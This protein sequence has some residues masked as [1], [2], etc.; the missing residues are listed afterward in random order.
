MELSD[1]EI[2]R[3]NP[4][5]ASSARLLSH[6]T[7][8]REQNRIFC[9]SLPARLFR[10]LQTYARSLVSACGLKF[11]GF[12][13]A[14]Q[15]LLSGLVQTMISS[16]L[17][18]FFK[19]KFHL[20]PSIVQNF[21]ALIYV[22]WAAKPLIG[23]FSDFFPILGYHKRYY[24][25]LA[26]FLG[27]LG[28]TI[29]ILGQNLAVGLVVSGFVLLSI[30]TSCSD[31]LTEGTYSEIAR[32][33]PYSASHVV[34][35]AFSLQNLGSIAAVT[36]VG[37]LSDSHNYFPI[38]I[39]IAVAA[40]LPIMPSVL[41]WLPEERT[42]THPP[43]VMFQRSKFSRSFFVILLAGLV[44]P[45]SAA[46]VVI[47][48]GYDILGL[49]IAL[50]GLILVTIGIY[51]T[52]PRIVA[53][54]ALSNICFMLSKPS[55]QYAISYYYT[56]DCV[57]DGPN[58]SYSF[59]ITFTGLVALVI[60][61]CS[62]WIYQFF[63]SEWS[64]RRVFLLTGSLWGLGGIFDLIL[65][66]RLNA[67]IHLPDAVVLVFGDA[68]FENCLLTLNSICGL[69]LMARVAPEGLESSTFALLAGVANSC[70][71]VR[72][73]IGSILYRFADINV[74]KCS[75]G[76]L[77]VLILVFN[78]FLPCVG[79]I[80]SAFLVPDLNPEQLDRDLSKTATAE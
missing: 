65:V 66:L 53:N 14:T 1:D 3:Q 64:F 57:A 16:T 17:L 72:G 18:P 23:L 32:K 29:V 56:S 36:I 46:C 43:C 63:F 48:P 50:A 35:F 62:L 49:S 52:F 80:C 10:P 6:G 11:L 44:I 42:S 40:I 71:S 79:G 39:I 24:V 25:V 58:F 76:N 21:A 55:L 69:T 77:W 4:A 78:I 73:L 45:I 38:F 8:P 37:F 59:Y 12:M 41:G 47:F 20:G 2:G 22:P 27:C 54:L 19:D 51:L 60:A 26:V 33:F 15:F 75:F 68:I 9:W 74:V 31:L 34:V 5:L 70:E 13:V 28:S 30:E 67:V 7:I 61:F